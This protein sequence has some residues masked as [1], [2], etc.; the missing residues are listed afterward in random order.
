[1]LKRL[2]EVYQKSNKSWIDLIWAKYLYRSHVDFAEPKAHHSPLWKSLLS[3]KNH[4][5]QNICIQSGNGAD[6]SFWYDRWLPSGALASQLAIDP[7][8]LCSHFRVRDF[9]VN[10]TWHLNA[11]FRW[12]TPT[13]IP[14][15]LQISPSSNPQQQDVVVWSPGSP[16]KFSIASA[17]KTL[18][19]CVG[20]SHK[21]ALLIWKLRIPAKMKY[22]LWRSLWQALPVAS[23]LAKIIPVIL[24]G[25]FCV[26]SIWKIT[27][28]YSGIALLPRLLGLSFF[29]H[30]LTKIMLCSFSWIGTNG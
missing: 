18:N 22:H 27:F 19:P 16:H 24:P 3:L 21:L 8:D 12:V 20:S 2:W 17:Y 6:T 4:L 1:M 11:L 28:I 30:P 7:P 15:I 26:S 23:F 5:L 10:Q 9:L 14:Q 25:V 29:P 13:L